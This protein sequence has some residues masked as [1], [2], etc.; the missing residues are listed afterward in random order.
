MIDKILLKSTFAV[1]SHIYTTGPSQKLENYLKTKTKRLVFIGHPFPYVKD[2]RSF[3]KLYENGNLLYEKKFI[4][5]KGPEI[6]FYAKDLILTFFWLLQFRK[7][8]YFVGID[9]LNAF[10]GFLLKKI[11]KVKKIIF[12]AIDYV[13]KRFPNYFLNHLYHWLDKKAVENSDK[14]WNL[15]QIMVFEREKKG[16]SPVFKKKQIEVPMGAEINTVLAKIGLFNKYKI[17]FLGHLRK[18]QGVEMLIEAM[19][20]IVKKVP[21][22][23]LWIIGGGPLKTAYRKKVDYL[24]LKKN[25]NF[26]GFIEDFASVQKILN[27]AAFALAPYAD[28]NKTYTRYTDPG[29][30]KDYLASGLPVIITKVPAVAFEIQKR[31]CGL[32]INYNERELIN[33]ILKFL[34]NEKLLL[35]YRKN[36]IKMAKLYQWEIIFK[37]AFEKTFYGL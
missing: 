20:E 14:V 10:A 12:Y 31:K 29:K 35:A 1:V 30:P 33:A 26:T 3:L 21:K 2:T 22:V 7:I 9:N 13:P 17:V 28:D 15:S 16:L 27:D 36:A 37:K 18:G 11:G 24:S 23:N 25:V 4:A 8:D 6:L 19:K 34:L 32:A 5:W